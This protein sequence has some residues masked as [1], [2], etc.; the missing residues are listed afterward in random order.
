MNGFI[1]NNVTQHRT[2]RSFSTWTTQENKR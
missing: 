2:P 1:S